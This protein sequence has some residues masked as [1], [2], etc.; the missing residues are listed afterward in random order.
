MNYMNFRN[1]FLIKDTQKL[2][3]PSHVYGCWRYFGD[4]KG[5]MLFPPTVFG[6]K[7]IGLE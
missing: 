3:C 6:K 4:I 1:L 7:P 5:L 2:Q